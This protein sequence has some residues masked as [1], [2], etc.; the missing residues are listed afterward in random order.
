MARYRDA[1]DWMVEN[2]DTEWAKDDDPMVSVTASLVADLFGKTTAQVTED[3][4]LGLR[5][6]G[7][8]SHV[9]DDSVGVMRIWDGMRKQFIDT[10]DRDDAE[11][12][13]PWAAEIIEADGGYWCFESVTDAATW[14]NQT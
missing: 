3:V 10:D 11:R 7:R 4:R 9:E 6:A 2:D 14:R 12:E 5:K 13:C 8:P 1:I